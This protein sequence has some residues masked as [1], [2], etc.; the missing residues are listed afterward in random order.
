ME[1]KTNEIENLFHQAVDYSKTSFE[2]IKLKTL[3]KSADVASSLLT[4]YMY[5]TITAICLIVLSLGVSYWLG[6]MLGK[7]YFGFL[8]VAG[9][10]AVT[11]IFLYLFLNKRIKKMFR[12]SIIK[13][14]F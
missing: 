3:D 5:F 6:E 11:G 4:R 13:K 1:E 8:T 14:A 9:F 2:I 12:N 7:I 10:W